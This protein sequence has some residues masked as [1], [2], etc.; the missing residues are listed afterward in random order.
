[1]LGIAFETRCEV[2]CCYSARQTN[3]D[4]QEEWKM[5]EYITFVMIDRL[6]LRY[7]N[8]EGRLC[9]MIDGEDNI[10]VMEAIGM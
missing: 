7:N 2:A 3:G 5:L 6:S 8:R 9:M 1:V 10:V 4:E